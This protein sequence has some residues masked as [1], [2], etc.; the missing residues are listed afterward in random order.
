ME[1]RIRDV[2]G[3]LVVHPLFVRTDRRIEGLVF[4][5]LLALLVRA[6]L[7]RTCQQRGITCSSQ[8]LFRGFATLQAIDLLWRDGSCQRRAA[9]MSPF[10]AEVMQALGWPTPE[11][12]A[13]LTP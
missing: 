1:K 4:I 3:P 8:R 12:Y 11:R 10:Q 13:E 7:E 9:E 6:I 5:T 2:K